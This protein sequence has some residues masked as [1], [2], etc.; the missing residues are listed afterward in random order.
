MLDPQ[1]GIRVK[2]YKYFKTVSCSR[3]PLAEQILPVYARHLL[4]IALDAALCSG[5]M[6]A[7]DTTKLHV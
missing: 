4:V 3:D 1:G 6:R 7:A 2:P 5:L